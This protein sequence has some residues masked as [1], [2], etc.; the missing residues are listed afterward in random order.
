MCY[1]ILPTS[2][3][4]DIIKSVK[5][6]RTSPGLTRSVSGAKDQGHPDDKWPTRTTTGT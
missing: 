3:M 2:C 5:P 4:S 1:D 6:A